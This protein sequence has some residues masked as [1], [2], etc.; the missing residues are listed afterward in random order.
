[1]AKR[2]AFTIWEMLVVVAI[3]AIVAALLFPTDIGSSREG[4]RRSICK[5]NL[6][7]IGLAFAQYAHD[8]D[9]KFPLTSTAQGWVGAL[10]PYAKSGAL[11]RCPSETTRGDEN[12]TDYW[13]NR[14]LANV[15]TKNIE[16]AQLTFLLGDGEAS[17]DAN[18][19]LQLLPPR[20]I[21]NENSPAHRHLDGANYGFADGHVKWMRPKALAAHEK[22]KSA[23]KFLAR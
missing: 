7:Q 1:M 11:F 10:Q 16:N 2:K 5:S 21:E 20:W 13:F 14:R 3:L 4:A 22:G 6:K 17:D 8:Y 9:D 19:S 12:L 18:V 15:K 23:P